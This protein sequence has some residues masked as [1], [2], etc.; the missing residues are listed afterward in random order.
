MALNNDTKTKKVAVM[1]LP[2]Y[3]ALSNRAVKLGTSDLADIQS[4]V[5]KINFVLAQNNEIEFKFE[6]KIAT[7]SCKFK[8]TNA[9]DVCLWQR[10]G[11]LLLETSCLSGSDI[12]FSEFYYKFLAQIVNCNK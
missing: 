8:K 2:C 12:T 4:A 9:I 1:E 5:F 10:E 11:E 3:I 6:P 7:W